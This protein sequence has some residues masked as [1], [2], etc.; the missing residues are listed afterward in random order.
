MQKSLIVLALTVL[1]FQSSMAMTGTDV[2]YV[3]AGMMKSIIN[4][5]NLSYLL[6]CMSGTDSLVT[7]L[8]NA[9]TDFEEG[10][11]TSIIAGVQEIGTFMDNIEPTYS[12]CTSI[13]DDFQKMADFFA[14][15]GDGSK[16]IST[17]SYNLLWN[18]SDIMTQIN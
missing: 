16:L 9:V 14:I 5:D 15:F 11:I 3:F 10:T 18:F 4:K 7:N 6:S 12:S 1:C 13:P 17:L 8:Q 2:I